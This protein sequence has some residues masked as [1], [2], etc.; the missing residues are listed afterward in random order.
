VVL[1]G[2][3]LKGCSSRAVAVAVAAAVVIDGWVAYRA[4]GAQIFCCL[5]GNTAAAARSHFVPGVLPTME[6]GVLPTLE[7]GVLLFEG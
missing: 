6:G 4:H 7:G 2:V 3:A 5:P 1:L